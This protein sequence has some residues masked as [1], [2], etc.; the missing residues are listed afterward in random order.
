[1][2][3]ASV[4]D[5]LAPEYDRAFSERIPARWLR[6]RVRREI[7]RYVAPESRVLDVGCGTGDDAVWFASQGHT[8]VATDVSAG[9][10][11][12]TRSK[13][14]AAPPEI[15]ARIAVVDLDVAGGD[16]GAA[17]G[18]GPFDLVHSNFGALN[19]VA[20][21]Q[22]FFAGLAGNVR[23]GGVVALTMMGRFCMW[24]T[25]G[26]A[27]RGDFR[28]ASR[29]WGGYSVYAKNGVEQPVWYHSAS[30]VRFMASPYFKVVSVTGIGVFVPSTEFF[31]VCEVRPRLFARLAATERM[32]GGRWPFNHS[33][34]HC[35]MILKP[36][37]P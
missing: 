25:A 16:A 20:S 26:F 33:G 28:R 12:L 15:G 18:R 6:Q 27:L 35:L 34:D 5:H 3:R 11:E 1:M 14:A 19:C 10:L 4:F 13:C 36:V 17:S 24:E 9:M 31:P 32:L 7:S 22:P 23:P 21:L 29:R 8:V 2:T 30:A 37:K